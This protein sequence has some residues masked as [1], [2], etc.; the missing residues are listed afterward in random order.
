MTGV[1]LRALT[2]SDL[3]LTLKW[4]NQADIVDLYSGHPFPVNKEMESK[5]YEKI[6]TS[7]F[8]TTVFGIET[9]DQPKLVGITVL[10]DINLIHRSAE[11]A[12]YIGD[13]EAR[14][15]GFSIEA[16]QMTIDFSFERLGLNRIWL[17]VRSDNFAALKLYQKT[18]F[19]EEGTLRQFE[20]KHGSFHDVIV[21]S[22]LR[23]E[24]EK[25]KKK[26][27]ASKR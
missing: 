25:E 15:K 8:P 5:W 9:I 6:V 21:L 2:M 10:K 14:G 17:K 26:D 24:Y 20:Y 13:M 27:S 12:I 16:L 11:T 3:P 18:G 23:E 22:I 7:N 1:K 19:I 4:H